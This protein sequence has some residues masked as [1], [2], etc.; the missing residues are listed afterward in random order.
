MCVR[1]R[2]SKQEGDISAREGTSLLLNRVMEATAK[3]SDRF[4]IG[5]GAQGVVYKASLNSGQVFAVKK[6][7]FSGNKGKSMEREIQTLGKIRHRNLVKLE[8]FNLD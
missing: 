2:K 8:D 1:G 6:L 7:A 4:I 3:L 5:R